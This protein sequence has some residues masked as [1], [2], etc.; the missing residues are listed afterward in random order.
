MLT[1]YYTQENCMYNEGWW[2]LLCLPYKILKDSTEWKN[3][4]HREI[5]SSS[6]NLRLI[7]RAEQN[8]N[9]S[10]VSFCYQTAKILNSAF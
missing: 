7:V 1:S 2:V 4:N 3:E 9:G 10:F 8:R 6:L 5:I